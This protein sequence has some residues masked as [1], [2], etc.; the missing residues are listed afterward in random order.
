[1]D[2]REFLQHLSRGVLSNMA[3]SNNGDGTIR[4]RD[5]HRVV[6]A[7]NSGLMVLHTIFTL[8][9]NSVTLLMSEGKTIYEVMPEFSIA[10]SGMP[11][12]Q[13]IAAGMHILDT[14]EQPFTGDVL[15]FLEARGLHGARLPINDMDRADSIY[16]TQPNIIQVPYPEHVVV[17]YLTYQASH[18]PIK[19]TQIPDTTQYEVEGFLEIPSVL[20]EALEQY[21]GYKI[22]DVLNTADSVRRSQML[23]V[24]FNES[25]QRL[26]DRD[27]LSYSESHTSERFELNGWR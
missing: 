8:R 10:G 21:V 23:E 1:M 16:T 22:Y 27:I 2:I 5:L 19:V 15:R 20:W 13:A 17:L 9:K 25:C 24:A 12:D 3:L 7:I 18:P 11:M 4:D 6:A 14:A 26:I